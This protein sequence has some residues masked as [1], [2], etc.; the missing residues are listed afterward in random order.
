MG[1]TFP[2]KDLYRLRGKHPHAR[3]EDTSATKSAIVTTETPPRT[4]GRHRYKLNCSFKSR[5]TPTHVG[6]TVY[7]KSKASSSEKHP[8]A[9]GEDVDVRREVA[10]LKETP[11][12]T[13]GRLNI[14]SL[15][16]H[17]HGN[18]PTHV[19]KTP[20]LPSPDV[21]C[22]KHP[23]AR[24]E[25]SRA[26]CLSIFQVETPP[27]TWGRLIHDPAFPFQLR[28]TPTHVGKTH[29]FCS[30]RRR[31]RKHPHARGED[32]TP[33][34]RSLRRGETPPRTWGRPVPMYGCRRSAGNTPT[35]VGKTAGLTTQ[36]R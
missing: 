29:L 27:R 22:E 20:A 19:G 4:W 15:S 6:K 28:N 26:V 11:P 3:G 35:H 12:R 2:K 9:R 8:H 30:L 10:A 5:N 25:D 36:A 18:T 33:L 17:K 1:K 7:T 23:H 16:R 31:W 34:E 32:H 24:G 21:L 13:W 14:L